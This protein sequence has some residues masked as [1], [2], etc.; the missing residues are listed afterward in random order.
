MNNDTILGYIFTNNNIFY[1]YLVS[2]LG[3]IK[4]EILAM[5]VLFFLFYARFTY[6]NASYLAR[7]KIMLGIEVE[8]NTKKI[9][10]YNI[11]YFNK[12]KKVISYILIDRATRLL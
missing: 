4:E 3:H 5:V 2:Y 10:N 1:F 6:I 9:K 12:T 11:Y 7:N 8:I